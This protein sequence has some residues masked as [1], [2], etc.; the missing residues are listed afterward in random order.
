MKKI[1]FYIVLS[2]AIVVLP[3]CRKER[4][5]SGSVILDGT[6]VKYLASGEDLTLKINAEG[7]TPS[8]TIYVKLMDNQSGNLQWIVVDSIK[9]IP[10]EKTISSLSDD[11]NYSIF[12]IKNGDTTGMGQFHL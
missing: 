10:H 8:S 6:T 4:F 11:K 12:L 1:A 5:Y 2:F 7:T 3:S 9:S